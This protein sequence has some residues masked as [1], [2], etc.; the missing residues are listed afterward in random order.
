MVFLCLV[1]WLVITINEIANL[2]E[3]STVNG[4]VISLLSC[5]A[6][7]H[8]TLRAEEPDQRVDALWG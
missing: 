4:S 2:E 5:S 7:K 1:F 8:T 3:V 6:P